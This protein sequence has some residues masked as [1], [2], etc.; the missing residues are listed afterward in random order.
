[1]ATSYLQN[2]YSRE[3]FV[4]RRRAIVNQ[5]LNIGLAVFLIVFDGKYHNNPLRQFLGSVTST[6]HVVVHTPAQAFKSTHDFFR[7]QQELEIKNE[8]LK[9]KVME[10]KTEL[11]QVR[12]R[13]HHHEI[14]T[15]WLKASDEALQLST[16]AN[17][18]TIEV[19][20]NRHI[21]LL[22]KGTKDGVFEGQVAV[23]GQGVVGQII[24]VGLYTSTLLLISD[25]KCS[26]P[27]M[28]K[29]TGEHGVLVGDNKLEKLQL[30]NVPKTN[31]VKAGD[32]LITSGL[33]FIY[34]YGIPVGTVSAV[35]AI[36]GE[37]FL[38]V[39][40]QPVAS[41]NKYHMVILLKSFADIK[42]WQEQ[43]KEREKIIEEES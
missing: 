30:L 23:D 43:L 41:L 35:K 38:Q 32:M 6:F 3:L 29:S 15:G 31:G 27:I 24:D 4:K 13:A 37:D 12:A 1:M 34:P 39:E 11:H 16:L 9:L 14:I 17:I 36:P 42:K 25:S 8:L 22:D 28:N 19:N 33:G 18:L 5:L 40:V 2:D 26:V 21:Y 20:S 7:S 10:L